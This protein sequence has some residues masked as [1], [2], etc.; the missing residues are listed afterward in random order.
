[1]L[2]SQGR[3]VLPKKDLLQVYGI[4]AEGDKIS[5]SYSPM[6]DLKFCY[7]IWFSDDRPI[8]QLRVAGAQAT[9]D[10]KMRIIVPAV[11]R[12]LYTKECIILEKDNVFYL[13]FFEYKKK[14]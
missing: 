5:F 6:G 8:N 4:V 9:V 13:V 11:I 2:D 3:I 10:A 12:K 7:R 1:M 14:E